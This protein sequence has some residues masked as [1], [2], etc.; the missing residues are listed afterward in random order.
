MSSP[1]RDPASFRDPGG[2][3][4]REGGKVLRGIDATTSG[5]IRELLDS[6]W[7][8]R[9]PVVPTR[10]SDR[11]LADWD[12]T[13]EHDRVP[14]ITY[15][16]EWSFRALREAALVYLAIMR[17]AVRHGWILKDATPYN[18]QWIDNKPVWIDTPSFEQWDGYWRGYSQFRDEF[19][20]PLMVTSHRG[21]AFQPLLRS[22]LGG[23]SL[24]QARDLF[25]G[26]RWTK[27]GIL[28]HIVMPM[29]LRKLDLPVSMT[30]KQ[31]DAI[32]HRMERLVARLQPRDESNWASYTDERLPYQEPDHVGKRDFVDVWASR[33]GPRL[34][35]DMGANTGEYTR[36]IARHSAHV[37]S[38]DGDPAAVNALYK[39]RP[40]NCTP[41]V[42]DLTN[43]S[44]RQGWTGTERLSFTDRVRPDFV[45]CLALWHHLRGQGIPPSGILDWLEILGAGRL[46]LEYVSP[47]DQNAQAIMQGRR[48]AIA[49]NPED[50]YKEI[51]RRWRV[52][53]Q[54]ILMN[55]HRTLFA[56]SAQ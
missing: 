20:F 7:Y 31:I 39:T 55:G 48:D 35:L 9:L 3:V 4:Y 43:P 56:L 54:R 49:E 40:E 29:L 36:I 16:Y 45:A 19:L 38:V 30:G 23:I 12:A 32:L 46:V 34:A 41:L 15:P 10:V 21:V 47:L 44:P 5:R 6:E 8:N 1:V 27:P 13:L 2:A 18:V 50:V 33:I 42:I 53:D 52:E 14:I 28:G 51:A 17:A 22:Q 11:V 25:R 37:V 24:D 26:T